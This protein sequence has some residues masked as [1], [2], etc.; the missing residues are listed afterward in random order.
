MLNIFKKSGNV[1]IS[2]HSSLSI[3]LSGK[4]KN[5]REIFAFFLGRNDED[6]LITKATRKLR[7]FSKRNSLPAK[8]SADVEHL[9]EPLDQN[10]L[11]D[12]NGKKC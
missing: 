12:Q 4:S 9:K 10:L 8:I 5:K 1:S 7:E 2:G 3:K 11:K 6:E